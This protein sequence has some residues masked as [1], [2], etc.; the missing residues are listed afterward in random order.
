MLM[1]TLMNIETVLYAAD[2]KLKPPEQSIITTE[3]L[4]GLIHKLTLYFDLIQH[5]I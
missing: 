1:H 4:K 2:N 5:V 3:K